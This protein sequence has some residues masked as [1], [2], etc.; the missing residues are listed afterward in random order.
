MGTSDF[1]VKAG[2]RWFRIICRGVLIDC[3]DITSGYES[4]AVVDNA[5]AHSQTL[6][7]SDRQVRD[8]IRSAY[9]NATSQENGTYPV[10]GTFLPDNFVI[11]R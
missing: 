4:Q 1:T 2:G 7:I 8:A 11:A 6:I 3:R 9:Y 5:T 10:G